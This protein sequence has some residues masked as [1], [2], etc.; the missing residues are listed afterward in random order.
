MNTQE[1]RTSFDLVNFGAWD[2]TRGLYQLVVD[3]LV[4]VTVA[5]EGWNCDLLEWNSNLPLDGRVSN[6]GLE[7][8]W[9]AGV[10]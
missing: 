7:V 3:C 10:C 8:V 4:F 6:D 9:I 5:E 2:C 1:V